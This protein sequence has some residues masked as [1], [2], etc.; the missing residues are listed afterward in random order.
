MVGYKPSAAVNQRTHWP[1]FSV[2]VAMEALD[3]PLDGMLWGFTT[4]LCFGTPNNLAL[5]FPM[6]LIVV[7]MSPWN[8][9]C[10]FFMKLDRGIRTT[11]SNQVPPP[12]RC[13]CCSK[14]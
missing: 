12:V 1:E 7:P 8:Q 11:R 10:N 14:S 5:T 13:A 6:V 2:L 9:E 4:G 3:V